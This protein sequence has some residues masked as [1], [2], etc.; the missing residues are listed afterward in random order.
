[1]QKVFFDGDVDSPMLQKLFFKK[2]KI[3]K[4]IL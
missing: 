1:M 4:N 2:E 3:K